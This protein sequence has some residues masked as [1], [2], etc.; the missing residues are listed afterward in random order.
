MSSSTVGKRH[1]RFFKLNNMKVQYKE[2]VYLTNPLI[3][4]EDHN[5][6]ACL[7][8]T[9]S[10]SKASVVNYVEALFDQK[11]IQSYRVLY[12]PKDSE[13]WYNDEECIYLEQSRPIISPRFYEKTK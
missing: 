7:E 11:L 2:L 13:N 12:Q 3:V 10:T 9:P 5:G 4:D 6:I 1:I 8:T